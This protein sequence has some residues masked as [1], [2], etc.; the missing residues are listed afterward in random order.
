MNF[1]QR[2]FDFFFNE[3]KGGSSQSMIHSNSLLG[4]LYQNLKIADFYWFAQ[5]N[6]SIDYKRFWVQLLKTN[7]EDLNK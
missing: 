7:S 6:Q 3:S 5:S 1:Y 4:I 2:N